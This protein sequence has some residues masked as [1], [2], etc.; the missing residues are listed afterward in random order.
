MIARTTIP[1]DDLDAFALRAAGGDASAFAALFEQFRPLIEA[2]A[3]RVQHRDDRQELESDLRVTFCEVIGQFARRQRGGHFAGLVKS[4]IQA[5]VAQWFRHRSAQKRAD[6]FTTPD[7]EAVPH[8][9][10]PTRTPLQ[11][12]ISREELDLTC[13]RLVE[14]APEARRLVCYMRQGFSPREAGALAGLNREETRLA[15]KAIHRATGKPYRRGVQCFVDDEVIATYPSIAA[16]SRASGVPVTTVHWC[17]QQPGRV[18][19]GYQWRYAQQPTGDD[20]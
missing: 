5:G 13:S 18:A 14:L 4:A 3:A 19:G 12:L 10:A 9:I 11:I 15:V 2:G 6:G 16:A 17:M 8:R 7:E 20:Q 1:H